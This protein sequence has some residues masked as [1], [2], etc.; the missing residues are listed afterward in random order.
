[1][2]RP[3]E[4]TE[5]LAV[6]PSALRMWT[7]EFTSELSERATRGTIPNGN[8]DTPTG[9]RGLNSNVQRSELIATSSPHGIWLVCLRA[10]I[11]PL[12]RGK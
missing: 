8:D 5:M 6:S 3:K 4:A 1:M 11:S 10:R 9:K 2:H 7:S 12:R